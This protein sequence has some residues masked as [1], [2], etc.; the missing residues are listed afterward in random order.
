[1]NIKKMNNNQLAKAA[2]L[3]PSV[4]SSLFTR[5]AEPELSTLSSIC[6]GLDITLSQFFA[7]DNDYGLTD[8]QREFLYLYGQL[9]QE[10]RA[11]ASSVL[12][13]FIK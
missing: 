13:A 5:S 3:N 10:K 11:L 1:M 7:E 2:N 9:P 6:S 12:K 4:I 8:D